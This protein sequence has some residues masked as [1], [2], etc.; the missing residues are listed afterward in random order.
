VLETIQETGERFGVVTRVAPARHRDRLAAL[1]GG[2]GRDRRRPGVTTK[3][4]RRVAELAREHRQLRRANELLKEEGS[5]N[6]VAVGLPNIRA[7]GMPPTRRRSTLVL[8]GVLRF[9]RG[10]PSRW[11]RME[12]LR[13]GSAL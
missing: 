5:P 11:V 2:E 1:P 10:P 8:C 4:R 6:T 12:S 13:T 3:G 9:G 7:A